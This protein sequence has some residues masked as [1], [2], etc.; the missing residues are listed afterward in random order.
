MVVVDA[1]EYN[2]LRGVQT[3]E[4]LIEAL[5]SSPHKQISI[6]PSRSPMPV[7]AVKL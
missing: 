5:Q 1:A 3:G 2:R 7:R 6:E 4:L